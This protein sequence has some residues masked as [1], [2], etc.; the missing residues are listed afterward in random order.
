MQMKQLS[1]EGKLDMDGIFNIMREE[2]PNQTE[3]F[4]LPY[5]RIRQYIPNDYDA[6]KTADLIVKLLQGW[7]RKRELE[8]DDAR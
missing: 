3:Q 8:R 1:A 2:K 7:Y 4:K 5:D 6:K